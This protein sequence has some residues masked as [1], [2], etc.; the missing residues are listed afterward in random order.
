MARD[1]A[2]PWSRGETFYNGTVKD[3]VFT[4]PLN[5]CGREYV[6]EVNAQDVDTGYPA[7]QDNSGR[8]IRVKVAQNTSGQNLLPGR[9]ARFAK[10]AP[11]EC[12]VDG[13]AWEATDD[14]AG[15]IDEFL[16]AAGVPTG[17]FFYLIV[18]GPTMVTTA[19]TGSIAIAIGDRLEVSD[20]GSAQTDVNAG[21][22]ASFAG[23]PAV[24]DELQLVGRA[25]GA[26]TTVDTLFPCVVHI[27]NHY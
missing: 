11:L 18:D 26:V 27:R 17:D 23:T 3:P 4:D 16:P 2:P 22:V 7:T 12:S 13:Y 19:H 15:V 8:P 14:I 20:T 24:G 1:E 25:E 10:V 5:Y 9:I 21:R 6:F